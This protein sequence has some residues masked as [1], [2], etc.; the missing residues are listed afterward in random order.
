MVHKIDNPT[1][2]PVQVPKL[3]ELCRNSL[4]SC[5][6]I[7]KNMQTTHHHEISSKTFNTAVI[8]QEAVI[9]KK[10]Q[11]SAEDFF[12]MNRVPFSS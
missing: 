3:S 12:S 4:N 2:F 6:W 8:K 9:L 10:Q 5:I 7:K 11:I 1:L